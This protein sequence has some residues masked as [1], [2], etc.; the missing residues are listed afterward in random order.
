[1]AALWLTLQ[2]IEEASYAS[3][4]HNGRLKNGTTQISCFFFL[5]V[6]TLFFLL[7][8]CFCY[9]VNLIF[10]KDWIGSLLSLLL[11]VRQHNLVLDRQQNAAKATVYFFLSYIT[12]FPRQPAGLHIKTRKIYSWKN[13]RDTDV[14][15]VASD[16]EALRCLRNTNP[17]LHD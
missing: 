10:W 8:C 1:M 2:I 15:V 7:L 9:P 11:E 14:L 16:A 4:H 13:E 6:L 12:S 17:G 5:S 3:R